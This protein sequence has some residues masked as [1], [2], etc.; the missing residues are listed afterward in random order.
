[1]PLSSTFNA[2]LSTLYRAIVLALL[3]GSAGALGGLHSG[4]PDS[5][6][7]RASILI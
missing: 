2:S 3:L 5:N 1:M 6:C 4:Q 7:Q